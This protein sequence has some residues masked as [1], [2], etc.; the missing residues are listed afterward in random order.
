MS[1]L[2]AFFAQNKIQT[3][4]IKYVASKTFVDPETKKPLEWELKKLDSDV[5]ESMKKSCRK[6][7]KVG[8]EWTVEQDADL[9]T[10]KVTAAAVVFPDLKDAELQNSFG[11]MGEEA[12]LR[13]MLSP[14]ELQRLSNKVA[15]LCDFGADDEVELIKEAK[16]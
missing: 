1:N 11:V 12:L 7:V 14:G 16:N 10:L 6:R 3:P 9:F 2:S 8:N 5:T 15:E 4:N 13:H